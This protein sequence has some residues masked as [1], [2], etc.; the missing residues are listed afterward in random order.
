MTEIIA[1]RGASRAARENTVEAFALAVAM[2]AD[3]IEL[4]VRRTARRPARRPSRCPH[5][6]WC[7]RSSISTGATCPITSRSARRAGRVRGC[8]RH[9]RYGQHRDQ[10]R[11]AEPDFDATGRSP[12]ASCAR[13]SPSARR[14]L[15]D[16]VVPT[17]DGRRRGRLGLPACARRGCGR[18]ARRHRAVAPERGHRALHPWVG[19]ARPVDAATSVTPPGWPSTR[20]RATTRIACAS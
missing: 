3:G 16:L 17:G 10:E 20:G 4:D 12:T 19:V 7:R 2:G 8:R 18:R 5:R 9:A 6:R 15:A 13:R 1:H 11:P 14:T